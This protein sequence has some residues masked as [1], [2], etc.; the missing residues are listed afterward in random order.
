MTLTSNISY[1]YNALPEIKFVTPSFIYS[2]KILTQ[3]LV[4]AFSYCFLFFI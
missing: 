2:F 1:R 4:P 3:F